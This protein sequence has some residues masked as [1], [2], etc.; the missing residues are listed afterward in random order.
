MQ[1]WRNLQVKLCDPC[2]NALRL[3]LRSKWR[4]INTLRFPFFFLLDN[5]GR[6]LSNARMGAALEQ[7]LGRIADGFPR[8][9]EKQLASGP[10][11]ACF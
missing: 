11:Q 9:C 1:A 7:K 2:L 6:S 10:Q 3:R 5:D 4:Y 8:V